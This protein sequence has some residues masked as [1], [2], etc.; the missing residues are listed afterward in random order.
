MACV[1][2]FDPSRSRPFA[3]KRGIDNLRANLL[4]L[5]ASTAERVG[6]NKILPVRSRLSDQLGGA[7][8][9]AAR[10]EKTDGSARSSWGLGPRK[11]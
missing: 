2:N 5:L 11:R 3:P 6:L 1:S 8:R 7:T 10:P 4:R 9:G